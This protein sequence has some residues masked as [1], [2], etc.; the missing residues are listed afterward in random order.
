MQMCHLP[1]LNLHQD[2]VQYM[3]Y[4]KEKF[5]LPVKQINL[6]H[7]LVQ[8]S[9]MQ[10]IPGNIHKGD[11]MYLMFVLTPKTLKIKTG[12]LVLCNEVYI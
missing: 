7:L 6:K 12:T 11:F 10:L 3:S 1:Y 5:R 9:L 8:L 2:S 4:Q